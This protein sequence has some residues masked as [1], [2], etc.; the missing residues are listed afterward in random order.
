MIKYYTE[1]FDVEEQ[2]GLCTITFNNTVLAIIGALPNIQVDEKEFICHG[3]LGITAS[4]RYGAVSLPFPVTGAV[5]S[6][7]SYPRWKMI[8]R[9]VTPLELSTEPL[10]LE[11]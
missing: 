3:K 11:E 6:L 9:S 4:G 8:V 1:F 10:I 5:V 2:D 7:E